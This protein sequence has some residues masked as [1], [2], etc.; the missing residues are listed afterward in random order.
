[1]RRRAQAGE[2]EQI[3]QS[4]KLFGGKESSVGAGKEIG[5]TGDCASLAGGR[6]AILRVDS[7]Q[8][9]RGQARAGQTQGTGIEIVVLRGLIDPEAVKSYARLGD[10]GWRKCMGIRKVQV[11]VQNIAKSAVAGIARA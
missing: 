9:N 2:G 11:L 4:G 7:I 10:P 6:S 1:M 5:P 8:Q 3:V